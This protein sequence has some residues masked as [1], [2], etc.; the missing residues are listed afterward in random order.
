[1]GK[2]RAGT[3]FRLIGVS[4]W[5]KFSDVPE[6]NYDRNRKDEMF[7]GRR[8]ENIHRRKDGR[9]EARVIQSHDFTGKAKYRY[10]YGKTYTEAKEKRNLFLAE[11]KEDSGQGRQSLRQQ[12]R[13]GQILIEWL[14]SKKGTIKE[15]TYANY[16]RLIET[17]LSPELGELYLAEITSEVLEQYLKNKLCSGRLDGKGGLSPKTV[18]DMRSVL[19][20]VVEYAHQHHY[21]CYIK[22]NM[23]CPKSR[24]PKIQVLTRQEQEKLESF[25]FGKSDPLCF[26]VL[27]ALYGGLRIGEVCA[28]R[29][30]DFHFESGTL[31]INKTLIRI[32]DVAPNAV[33]KTKLLIETPKTDAADRVIPLPEFL[34]CYLKKYQKDP[35]CYLLTGTERYLEPRRYLMKYK[36]M[37]RQAGM[38]EITFHALR[39]TFA[40]RCVEN[41]FDAK[42]LS[43]I[44]G[45]ANVNTT[46][47]RYVH[48]SMEQK[49]EQMNMLG[50]I[51]VYSQKSG[52]S[53]KKA[54]V[55]QGK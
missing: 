44:L 42:S 28:L 17:H 39:H 5:V 33:S 20:M 40:T 30:E 1:M 49:K 21:P 51:S 4:L 36:K 6:R 55:L 12:V 37:L 50:K 31:C 27:A 46:L 38:E 25:L 11:K 13:F 19:R 35:K 34:M 15:S 2:E 26:G 32:R 16:L 24:P 18:S 23:F 14:E 8:G 47:Q 10:F 48:P 29:W 22:S 54:A 52:Q 7:M 41:G 53:N 43:E 9:W 45:H 3:V